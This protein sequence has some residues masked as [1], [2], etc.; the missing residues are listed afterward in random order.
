MPFLAQARQLSL[1]RESSSI[2]QD[3]TLPECCT[4]FD[5]RSDN[6]YGVENIIGNEIQAHVCWNA[7]YE[8]IYDIV[9]LYADEVGPL[10]IVKGLDS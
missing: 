6:R 9:Y 4:S 1:R 3:F 8:C 2:A 7:Y 5:E 10:H